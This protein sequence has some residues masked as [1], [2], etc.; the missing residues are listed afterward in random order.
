M[1]QETSTLFT[2]YILTD[3]EELAGTA[4]STTQ[5]CFMQ[6]IIAEAAEEKVR[7]TFDPLNP[8]AFIQREAELQG[9]ILTLQAILARHDELLQAMSVQPSI[10]N[11]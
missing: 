6:N 2:K 11:T 5:R 1:A 7:L 9:T 4:F 8:N 10:S 3:E